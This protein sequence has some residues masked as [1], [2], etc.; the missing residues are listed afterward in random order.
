MAAHAAEH[1]PQTAEVGQAAQ[2]VGHDQ[3]AALAQGPR[4][5][6]SQLKVSDDLVEDCLDPHQGPGGLGLCLGD[7]DGPDHGC[8]DLAEQAPQGELCPGD[9]GQEAQDLVGQG[10]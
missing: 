7:A 8:H 9:P 6:A 2:G 5:G 4:R 10:H 3:S 1:E